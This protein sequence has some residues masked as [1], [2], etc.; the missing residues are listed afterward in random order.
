MWSK[1]EE[2][3]CTG[4][5]FQAVRSAEAGVDVGNCESAHDCSLDLRRYDHKE[6]DL[7]E[8]QLAKIENLELGQEAAGMKM[9]ANPDRV[10]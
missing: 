9:P 6:V 8:I 2:D 3:S 4:I 5:G 10:A 7:P 1:V